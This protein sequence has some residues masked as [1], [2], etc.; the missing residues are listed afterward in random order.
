MEY[1]PN[2]QNRKTTRLENYNYATSGIYF[3]TICTANG[4]HTFGEIV[5]GKMQYSPQGLIADVHINM[6]HRIN[7]NVIDVNYVVMP[8]HIHLLITY[9]S[10]KG[11][12]DNFDV[13]T[14]ERK[15]MREI[16]RDEHTGESISTVLRSL[17]SGIT[18]DG[19]R[20]G[21]DLRWLPRFYD[22]VVRNHDEKE[23]ILLYIRNNPSKWDI[24]K[25]MDPMEMNWRG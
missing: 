10:D 13:Y 20:L 1:N 2:E 8:N 21:Y 4:E 9:V 15:T 25:N 18:R 17:K 16:R 11:D 19:H 7:P 23:A 12:Q 22:Y 14:N 5:D 24:E 3:I 6:L